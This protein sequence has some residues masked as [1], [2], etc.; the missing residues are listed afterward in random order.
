MFSGGEAFNFSYLNQ[1]SKKQENSTHHSFQ[2]KYI[3]LEALIQQLYDCSYQLIHYGENG[4]PIYANEYM[5]LS[6]EVDRLSARLFTYTPRNQ[7]EEALLCLVLLMS[8]AASCTGSFSQKENKVNLV[9]NRTYALLE[10]T[11]PR[12][13]TPYPDGTLRCQLTVYTYT[14]TNDEDLRK[15]AQRLISSWQGRNLTQDEVEIIDLFN[16]LI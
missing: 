13:P 9:L 16:Q 14:F 8:Y 5:A 1:A 12:W 6:S 11:D 2:N 4:K 10:G 7:L 3:T 15:E